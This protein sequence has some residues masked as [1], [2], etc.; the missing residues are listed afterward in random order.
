MVMRD[1]DSLEKYDNIW[2]D[3]WM[4]ERD[5]NGKAT[6]TERLAKESD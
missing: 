4:T 5:D 6:P 2:D 1:L 3:T